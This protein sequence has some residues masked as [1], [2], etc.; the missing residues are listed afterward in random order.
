MTHTGEGLVCVAVPTHDAPYLR[1]GVQRAGHG[2][3]LGAHVQHQRVHQRHVV[4]RGRVGVDGGG[5]GRGRGTGATGGGRARRAVRVVA[6]G[7]GRQAAL[8]QVLRQVGRGARAQEGVHLL[9]QRLWD[10]LLGVRHHAGELLDLG[11]QVHL[12]VQACRVG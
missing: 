3:G 4:G 2:L 10:E 7:G 1:S 12:R 9:P 5:A 8:G 6:V 11:E